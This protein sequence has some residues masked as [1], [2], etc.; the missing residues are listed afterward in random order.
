MVSKKVKKRYIY[1]IYIEREDIYLVEKA[2]EKK[3]ERRK[4][5]KKRKEKEERKGEKKEKS[6]KG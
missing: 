1:I 2:R 5:K 6:R 3:R 4:E